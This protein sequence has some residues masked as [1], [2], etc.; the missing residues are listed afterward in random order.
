[1]IAAIR[2][3]LSFSSSAKYESSTEMTK[4]GDIQLH[5]TRSSIRQCHNQASTERAAAGG[6]RTSD[7]AGERQGKYSEDLAQNLGYF[8]IIFNLQF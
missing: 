4:V 7:S 1:M 3:I 5:S 2:P 6:K 8:E